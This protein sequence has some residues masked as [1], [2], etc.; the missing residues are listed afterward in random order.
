MTKYKM[1]GKEIDSL[2]QVSSQIGE[3]QA[4]NKLL[5]EQ[6]QKLF[7]CL[8]QLKQEKENE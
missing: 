4:E 7:D 6:N 1:T 2:M 5:K 8:K 3:L